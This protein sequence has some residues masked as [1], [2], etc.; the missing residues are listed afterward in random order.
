MKKALFAFVGLFVCGLVAGCAPIASQKII[1]S[2][3]IK[4]PIS[5]GLHYQ[6]V[7]RVESKKYSDKVTA[8]L[9]YAEVAELLAGR[10]CLVERTVKD[11]PKSKPLAPKEPPYSR[12]PREPREPLF[13]RY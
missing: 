12:P 13:L 8:F 2:S 4:C 9:S 10:V 11:A 3:A 7:Y 1:Y 5:S 6:L